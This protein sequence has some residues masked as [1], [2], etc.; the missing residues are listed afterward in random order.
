MR[1]ER[2]KTT[3]LCCMDDLVE[4]AQSTGDDTRA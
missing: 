4:T 3:M 2:P 1:K